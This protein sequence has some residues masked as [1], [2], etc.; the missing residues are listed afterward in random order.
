MREAGVD[1]DDDIG[2]RERCCGL[3]QREPRRYDGAIV[4]AG[5]PS[6][7]ILFAAR[8]PWQYG[9]I[10]RAGEMRDQRSPT[11][12]GP[13]FFWAGCRMKQN[14]VRPL[15]NCRRRY[16]RDDVP[17]RRAVQRVSECGGGQVA[18]ALDEVQVARQRMMNIMRERGDG[19]ADAA[20][21]EAVT[22]SARGAR[23]QCAFDLFLQVEDCRI[24][25]FLELA[26][27][28]SDFPPRHSRQGRLAPAPQGEGN[29]VAYVRAHVDERHETA[30]G[31]PIDRKLGLVPPNVGG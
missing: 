12:F 24:S 5:E 7:A 22:A 18:A 26:P 29:D 14:G 28:R 20:P 25:V 31:D 13:Q 8:A 4:A 27:K 6:A 19:L 11:F 30:L 15:G 21:I 3:R 16:A 23:N 10:A 2:P 17:A 9:R 1:A